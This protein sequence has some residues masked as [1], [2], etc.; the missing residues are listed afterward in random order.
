MLDMCL[1]VFLNAVL[2]GRHHQGCLG[3]LGTPRL[4]KYPLWHP[5]ISQDF[6]ID[7]MVMALPDFTLAPSYAS[8]PIAGPHAQS[9][10][11][12]PLLFWIQN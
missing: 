2:Q 7:A 9:S 4:T 10:V 1:L 8:L 12:M 5:Q 3:Q 6:N 11:A